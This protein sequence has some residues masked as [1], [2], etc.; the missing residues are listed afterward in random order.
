MYTYSGYSPEH[1]D[2]RVSADGYRDTRKAR[3]R[4]IKVAGYV[5]QYEGPLKERTAN[6]LRCDFL[7]CYPSVVKD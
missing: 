2:Q 5:S 4:I 7:F 1:S 3:F 6:M